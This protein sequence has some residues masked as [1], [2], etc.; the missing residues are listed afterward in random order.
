MNVILWRTRVNLEASKRGPFKV[1]EGPPVEAG[2]SPS[3]VESRLS[4]TA[5]GEARAAYPTAG[6]DKSG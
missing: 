5:V 3:E 4:D 1:S 2:H 6:R